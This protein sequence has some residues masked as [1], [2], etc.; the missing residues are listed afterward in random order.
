MRY[1][2]ARQIADL[3][4]A[5]QSGRPARAEAAIRDHRERATAWML[6][7]AAEM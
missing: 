4:V 1:A 7:N 3:L 2:T 5:I 6:E